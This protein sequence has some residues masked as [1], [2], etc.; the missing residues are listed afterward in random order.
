ML[1]TFVILLCLCSLLW[2]GEVK[3][4]RD[5][6]A[7]QIES[8]TQESANFLGLALSSVQGHN[9]QAIM[10]TMIDALFD[11]GSYLSIELLDNEGQTLVA[12]QQDN[13]VLPVPPWFSVQIDLPVPQAE[14]KVM[15]GWVQTGVVRIASRLDGAYQNLWQAARKTA[16]WCGLTWCIFVL[17]GGVVLRS[18]LQPLKRIE[19]QAS[20]LMAR[21]FDV[22]LQIPRTRELRRGR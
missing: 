3:R 12:R 21:R 7:Q 20:A 2:L 8:Q 9:E 22:Q 17:L 5:Y 4:T 10:E 15:R 16:L 13:L 6:L 19:E 18:I 14:A 11:S 1:S